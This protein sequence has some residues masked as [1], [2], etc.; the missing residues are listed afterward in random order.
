MKPLTSLYS[1][2]YPGTI[3]Y[4]LQSCEYR[5]IPYLRWLWRTRDFSTVSNRGHLKRTRYA[6]LLLV[7]LVAGIAIEVAAGLS[8]IVLGIVDGLAGYWAFGA[9]VIVAY[10]IIWP[11]LI[12]LPLELG[13]L[14]VVEPK[15]E[16]E[17]RRSADIFSAHS[18]V[19][20]AVAGSYG[21]T[22]MK[23]VL[24]TV[25]SEGKRVA[26]TEANHN[27]AIE[28]AKF[29][30]R[31][32]GNEEVLIIEYG[33]GAPGDVRKFS[34][35]THPTHGIITGLAPAHLDSYKTME[36]AAAD[37]FSLGEYLKGKNVY[38][39]ADSKAA[40][41]H[42]GEGYVRYGESGAGKWKA[43]DISVSASGLK[44][45][46]KNGKRT[47]ELESHMLGRH[48][49]GT[50]SLAAL[51]GLELGLS[52]AQVKAGIA[53]TAPFEHR[54]QPYQLGGALII[55]DTYNGNID[56]VRAGTRL[57][58]E[59]S[60]KRKIYVTPGL[61]EQGNETESVHTEMGRL[62]AG[63][64]PNIVVL[65][66]NSVTEYIRNGLEESSYAGEL[67]IEDKPLEF[68]R[69]LEHFVAAG[70]TVMMQNDWPD[71]YS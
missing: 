47:L 15:Q 34:A 41:E 12:V 9:A 33:E 35:N 20:I 42:I 2:R 7:L 69:N 26:A 18:A 66:N 44:F 60:S 8:L 28:H 61:V 30:H 21:K 19:K 68:Y 71:N 24:N 45:K 10:P 55:D 58:A 64:E 67:R 50:L 36:A 49:V 14:Y 38:V 37:I 32:E 5:A 23:E 62:I 63:S 11:H 56:G 57:L 27:V 4:M 29:A 16:G 25:L 65:M 1:L 48:Q 59:L 51:L 52:E 46:L 3:I 40:S 6:R 70:D 53:N 43:T 39:N 17:V 31:L 13:R 22:T 54:M